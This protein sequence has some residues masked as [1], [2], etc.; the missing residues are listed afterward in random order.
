MISSL[1]AVP[2]PAGEEEEEAAGGGRCAA[3]VAA[4]DIRWAGIGGG[5]EQLVSHPFGSSEG[6]GFIRSSVRVVFENAPLFAHREGAGPAPHLH[7]TGQYT[8]HI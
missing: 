6:Q 4:Q 7:S 3:G 1:A 5:S 2:H 8:Q